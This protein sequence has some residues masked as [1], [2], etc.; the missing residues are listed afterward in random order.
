MR[1]LGAILA[2]GRSSRFGSD[3]ASALVQGVPLIEWVADRLRPQCDHVIVVGR[4]WPGLDR[5]DDVPRP[6]MGPL[7]G[8]AGALAYAERHGFDDVLICPCDMPDIP[9]NLAGILSPCPAFVEEHWGWSR[10]PAGLAGELA[11]WLD[12]G[13]SLRLRDW[14]RQQHARSVKIGHVVRNINTPSDI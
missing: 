3:K 12:R 2:G 13:E 5:A 6:G 9:A 7:G 14:S 4:E 8:M 1:L 10:W 11:D